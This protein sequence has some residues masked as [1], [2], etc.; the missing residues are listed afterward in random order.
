MGARLDQ[1]FLID[2]AIADTIVA[3]ARIEADDSVLEIGPGRGVL[4]KLLL[5]Q[6]KQVTVVEMDD[7]LAATLQGRLCSPANLQLVHADFLKVNMDSL[8]VQQVKIVSNLPYSV[9]TPILQNLLKWPRWDSAVLMF[10]KEV[11]ERIIAVPGCGDYGLL[12]LSVLL[13]AEAELVCEVG[14]RSFSPPPKVG[15]AVVRLLRRAQP[16]IAPDKEA[17]FFKVA[18]AAFA[19]RRKMAAGPISSTLGLERGK[20]DA[21][22]A[23]LAIPAGARAENIPLEAWLKLPELL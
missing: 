2:P 14:R 18:K 16:L 7:R 19:Q 21:A 23:A 15:S 20:V 22:F 10:Q 1:H 5:A 9:A 6:A 11:A 3:A 17:A 8:G 12:T 13:Y 4:T